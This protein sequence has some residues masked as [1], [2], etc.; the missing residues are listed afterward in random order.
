MVDAYP[1]GVWLVELAALQPSG[2]DR[3]GVTR[4]IAGALGV[5]EQPEE[6]LTVT[7]AAFLAPRHLL[8]LLDNC[9]HLLAPCAALTAILLAACPQL[10]LLATSREGLGVPGEMLFAVPSLSVPPLDVQPE[11]L[12]LYDAAVLFLARATRVT[13]PPATAAAA[14]ARICARLDGIPLAVELAAARTTM[15]HVE[16]LADRLADCFHVLTTGARTALPRQRTLRATLEW[17]YTLLDERER[18]L[19][20]RLAVFAGGWSV[21]AAGAVCSDV[22]GSPAALGQAALRRHAVP[23]LLGALVSKSLVQ[24]E[25]GGSEARYRFL[26]PIRQYAAETLQAAEGTADLQDRHLAW[27]SALAA[28][29]EPCLTGPEQAGWLVRLEKEHDNLRAALSWARAQAEGEQGLRLAGALWRF[30]YTRGYFGEGQDWLEAVLAASGKV[31]SEARAKALNG[32]GVLAYGQGDCERAAALHEECLALRRAQ[33]DTWGVAASLG[34]LGNVRRR[35]GEFERAI[36]LH[37]ESLALKRELGDKPGIAASLI[38]LGVVAEQQGDFARATAL[39]EESLALKRELGD[40]WGVAAALNNLGCIVDQ[41]GDYK[42]AADLH[43][44][45][46]KLKRELGDKLGIV[47][48]LH[49][50]ANVARRQGDYDRAAALFREGLLLSSE[51]GARNELAFSLEGVAMVAGATGPAP[52]AA[53]LAAAAESLREAIGRPM[54]ASERADHEVLLHDLRTG[55]SDEV[56]AEAWA[57]GRALSPGEAV[58]LALDEHATSLAAYPCPG[59]AIA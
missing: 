49:N 37:E 45:S 16:A 54:T 8:L 10:H 46:L 58:A 52:H 7:L 27:C 22:P 14:I 28:E 15:L 1:D 21:E 23:M 17:S 35:Q 4:A 24:F 33:R 5:R 53:Y 30:W 39:C 41:Q 50:L 18:T 11:A 3:A 26:E 43:E 20:R 38:N 19:L 42:R 34:N 59:G 32:A 51:I 55:M 47:Y 29:A 44:E 57:E 6:P 25:T 56:L 48:S 13:E 31:A 2:H 36:A 40:T 12:E 9:E